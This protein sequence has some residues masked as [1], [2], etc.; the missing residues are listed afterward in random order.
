MIKVS[1]QMMRPRMLMKSS[2]PAFGRVKDE[3]MY[4]GDVPMWPYTTPS[5]W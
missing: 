4:N 2:F 5:D 1:V 3:S